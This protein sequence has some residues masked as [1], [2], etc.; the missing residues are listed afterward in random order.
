M[1]FKK[2]DLILIKHYDLKSSITL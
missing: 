2:V 1:L